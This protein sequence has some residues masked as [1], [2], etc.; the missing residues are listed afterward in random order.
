MAVAGTVQ[1]K[2]AV[3]RVDDPLE[4]AAEFDATAAEDAYQVI[5]GAWPST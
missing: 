1:P 4:R 5:S 3:G 2:L